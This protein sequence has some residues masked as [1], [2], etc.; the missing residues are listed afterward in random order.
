MLTVKEDQPPALLKYSGK[1]T[2][3]A[4]RAFTVRPG[5]VSAVRSTSVVSAGQAAT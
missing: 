5:A 1:E 2:L 4:A 3:L